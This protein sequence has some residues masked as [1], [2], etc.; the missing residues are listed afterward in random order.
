MQAT[1]N[2]EG[3]LANRASVD[4]KATVEY[5]QDIIPDLLAAHCPTGCDTV[6]LW[7]GTEKGKILKTPKMHKYCLNLLR[8]QSTDFEE[9]LQQ[10]TAFIS[11]YGIHDASSM[12]ASRIKVWMMKSC[13]RVA[14]GM[15]KLCSLPPTNAFQENVK[16]A[17]YLYCTWKMVL[18]DP[19]SMNPTDY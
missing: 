8:E 7:H 2:F 15:P 13:R 18:Q 9:V 11:A 10:S 4:I 12:T 17:H 6:A 1:R 19:P 14:T 16:R 3:R 5:L